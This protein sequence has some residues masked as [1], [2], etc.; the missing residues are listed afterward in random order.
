MLH[1][2]ADLTGGLLHKVQYYATYQVSEADL[3]VI[4]YSLLL[5]TSDSRRPF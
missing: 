4:P 2:T 3:L 1:S 5:N